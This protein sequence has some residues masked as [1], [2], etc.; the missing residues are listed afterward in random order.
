MRQDLGVSHSAEVSSAAELDAWLASRYDA[1]NPWGPS[2]DF[3]L[4]WVLD[5]SSVLDVGCGT[6]ALLVRARQDGHSGALLGVDPDA[7]MLEQA[8]AKG[9][10]IVLVLG[11]A[12]SL[13]LGRRVDLITMTGHAFQ[14]LLDDE[15]TTAAL[16]R[17]HNH[18]VPGGRLVFET[19]N[20]AAEA[21]RRWN[22]EDSRSTITLPDGEVLEASHAVTAR[23]A[24]DLVTY[25]TTFVWPGGRAVTS[26]P[27]TLRFVS[28]DRLLVLVEGAGF[29][30]LHQL[31]DWDGG[32][33]GDLSPE[34]IVV[35]EPR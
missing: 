13:D 8:R 6:G 16:T 19:R 7:A 4:R 5:A 24:P 22:P 29:R 25:R 31:G 2:D 33:F 21:W 26:E 15:Q 23:P 10:Q 1:M 28:R 17:F 12:Q 18:L 14:V 34:L 27:E 9:G 11:D 35:A 20:P 32:E 30:V 3:Y